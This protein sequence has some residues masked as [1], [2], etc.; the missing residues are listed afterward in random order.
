MVIILYLIWWILNYGVM[1]ALLCM[2]FDFYCEFDN[3]I[4][5]VFL[6]LSSD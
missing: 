6:R 4:F 3:V 1:I 5:I 2:F